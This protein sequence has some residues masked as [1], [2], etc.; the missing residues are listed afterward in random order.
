M[1]GDVPVHWPEPVF[2]SLTACTSVLIDVDDP[3]NSSLFNGPENEIADPLVN[4]LY[5]IRPAFIKGVAVKD[6][7]FVKFVSVVKLEHNWNIE[8]ISVTNDNWAAP[9]KT[10][11]FKLVQL[12]KAK[13]NVVTLPTVFGNV[14]LGIDLQLLNMLPKLVQTDIEVGKVTDVS[15]LQPLKHDDIVVTPFKL[16]GSVTL[17]NVKQFAK[18]AESVVNAVMDEGIEILVNI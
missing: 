13:E 18:V 8:L 2:K 1:W 16:E 3:C 5:T 9:G 11:V 12:L 6:P 7:I 14:I 10:Q 4:L 17:D 15:K